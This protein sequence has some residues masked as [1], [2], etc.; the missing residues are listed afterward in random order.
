MKTTID[1]ADPLLRE[2]GEIAARE[3]T[4]VDRLV[5]QSLRRMVD[6]RRRRPGSAFRLRKASFAGRGLRA[7][8]TEAGW[9]AVRDAVYRGRGG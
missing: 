3:S 1:I 9:D 7:E 4:T 2:V 5:E 8:I 6:E